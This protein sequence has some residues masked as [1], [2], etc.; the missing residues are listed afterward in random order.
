MEI[1][2]PLPYI[3]TH[4]LK[5]KE[6]RVIRTFEEK[7]LGDWLI[8]RNCLRNYHLSCEWVVLGIS[9]LFKK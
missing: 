5:V 6:K 4:N 1:I 8:I 3:I 9:I 7:I 2:N